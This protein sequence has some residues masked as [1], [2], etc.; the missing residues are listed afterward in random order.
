LVEGTKTKQSELFG[1]DRIMSALCSTQIYNSFFIKR[2]LNIEE[3]MNY[4]SMVTKSLKMKYKVKHVVI[5]K[6]VTR[7]NNEENGIF[8]FNEFLFLNF[9]NINRINL[10]MPI[11]LNGILLKNYLLF[12]IL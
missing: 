3:T 11:H 1:I 9:T 12:V 7:I 5:R 2:T 10:Y 4:F 6:I 8:F